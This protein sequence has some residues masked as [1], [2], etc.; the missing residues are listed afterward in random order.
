MK[1]ISSCQLPLQLVQLYPDLK[2]IYS[3]QSIVYAAALYIENFVYQK[4]RKKQ[5]RADPKQLNILHPFATETTFMQ[6]NSISSPGF[7]FE[8]HSDNIILPD[9]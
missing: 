8:Q 5:L 7:D 3:L 1:L 9:F 4:E 2:S 6:K